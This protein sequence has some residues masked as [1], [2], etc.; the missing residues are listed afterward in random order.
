MGRNSG[1]GVEWDVFVEVVGMGFV[2]WRVGLWIANG[3]G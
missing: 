1:W 2:A 3:Y